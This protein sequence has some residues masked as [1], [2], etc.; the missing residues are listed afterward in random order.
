MARR[1][2]A[3]EGYRRIGR[4]DSAGLAELGAAVAAAVVGWWRSGAYS[5]R[6]SAAPAVTAAAA[7][8]SAAAGLGTLRLSQDGVLLG[9]NA[10]SRL[11]W[12]FAEVQSSS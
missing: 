4:V 3:R 12:G 5:P 6:C 7:A 1:G 11:R 2:G 8:A 9:A 10:T